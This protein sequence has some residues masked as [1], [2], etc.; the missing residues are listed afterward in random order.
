MQPIVAAA[1]LSIVLQSPNGRNEIAVDFDMRLATV[2]YRISRDGQAIIGPTPISITVNGTKRPSKPGAP[3]LR[4]FSRDNPVEPI[5]PT[6]AAKFRDRYNAKTI[7]FDDDGITLELRA[8]DDGV[9]FRW[10]IVG[11]A[12]SAA[13]ANTAEH[14]INAEQLAFQFAKNFTIYFPQPSGPKFF[15]HQ[16]PKFEKLAISETAG[17]ATACTPALLELDGGQYLLITD[18]NVV[19]YPG[20]W[21]DGTNSTTMK[22]TFPHHPARTR[23]QQDRNVT[24]AEYADYLVEK[25]REGELPWRAFVLTDAPGLLQSTMLYNLA[26][27]HQSGSDWSWIKP[28][29]V[30]WDWW[31]AWNIYDLGI[32]HGV[33]QATYKAY[34]DFASANKLEYVILD[35]GWSQQGP[36]NLLKVVPDINMHRS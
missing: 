27:P 7:E 13:G 26:T 6:I 31:N 16:E 29:K 19:S 10:S 18:V 1:L 24:V 5:V 25:R 12:A 9:A 22:A 4:E 32:E 3:S 15:S 34:I 33:N 2:A 17:K 14:K 20:M 30:A 23:L 36:E 28:G 35:E 21:L 11:V 8:Y